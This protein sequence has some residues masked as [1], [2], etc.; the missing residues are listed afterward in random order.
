MNKKVLFLLAYA[1]NLIS[2]LLLAVY[3]LW[4]LIFIPA[5]AIGLIFAGREFKASIAGIFGAIGV[6]LSILVYQPAFRI[7]EASLLAGII[8]IPFGPVIVILILL[9]ISFL[10]VFLGTEIGC[11]TRNWKVQ[12]V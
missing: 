5:L 2:S 10:L 4:Y 9:V 8:G 7:G 3:G 1:V 6:F 11:S 12:K